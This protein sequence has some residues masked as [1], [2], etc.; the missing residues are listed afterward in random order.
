MTA[1]G[2]KADLSQF[3]LVKKGMDKAGE[4]R[5]AGRSLSRSMCHAGAER[6]RF[7]P[8]LVMNFLK[9]ISAFKSRVEYT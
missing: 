5:S 7:V 4:L 1:G 9:A 2:V 3:L 6:E 8:L